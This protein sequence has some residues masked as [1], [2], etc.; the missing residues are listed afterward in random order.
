MPVGF[1]IA[2]AWVDIRAEDKGLRQEI[3]TAVENATKGQKAK[4]E[5]DILTKG[6]RKQV[7]A[8]LAEAT[9]GQS[10]KVAIGIKS[11]GLRKEVTEA[12]KR[13]TAKQKPTVKL[14]I[15]TAGL[16]S[17]VQRA[18]A[19]A[20][21]D[22]KPTVR[23]GISSKGL[24]AEV[25]TAIAAATA[26]QKATVPLKIDD[27]TF[28]NSLQRAVAGATRGARGKVKVDADG[29][30]FLNSI[31]KAV[32]DNKTKLSVDVD[33]AAFRR[34][35][36]NATSDEEVQVRARAFLN[37]QSFRRD[38]NRLA[39][40]Q[41]VQING[42]IN[43]NSLQRSLAQRTAARNGLN[44]TVN[45][46]VNV[47][48]L[49]AQLTAAGRTA[50][51]TTPSVGIRTHLNTNGFQRGAH[52]MSRLTK[53]I[54]AS[55]IFV[56]PALAV[57]DTALRAIGP[58]S[59][60]AVSGLVA[61]TT[62]G[63]TL[64]VGMNNVVNAI[65][66]SSISLDKYYGFLDQLTPAARSFVETVVNSKGAWKEFQ[67]VIQET[68]F[69]NLDKE[70]SHLATQTIPTFTVGLGGMAMVLNSMAKESFKTTVAMAKM[71]DLD[72]MFG[73]LHLAMKP[74][75]P[76]PGQILNGI[77][78]LGTAAMP[79]F[80][81]MN[82][83]MGNWFNTMTAK[84]NSAFAD[85]RL[86]AA[87]TKSADDIV[88]WFRRIAN[89]PEFE[90]FMAHMEATG[91]EMS[92][93]LGHITEALAKLLN[94]LSPVAGAIIKVANAFAELV[95]A[96]PNDFIKILL[97]AYATFK[98]IGLASAGIGRTAAAMTRLSQAMTGVAA[99]QSVMA[100]IGARL[101]TFGTAAAGILRS[102]NALG[103]LARAGLLLGGIALTAWA[104]HKAMAAAFGD[105]AVNVDK[106]TTSLVEFNK[107]GRLSGEA[108]RVFGANWVQQVDGADKKMGGLRDAIKGIAHPGTWDRM[109]NGFQKATNWLDPGKTKLEKYQEKIGGVDKAL[110]KL[111]KDG[112]MD[113]AN[114]LFGKL[115]VEARKSGT[116]TEKF[117]TL[118]PKYTEA[119]KAAKKAQKEAAETMG[120]FGQQAMDVADRIKT[121]NAEAQG[122]VKSLFE[123]NNVN[124][125]SI[126]ASKNW[127]ESADAID[128]F[129]KANKKKAVG[130]HYVNGELTTNNELQREAATLLDTHAQNT[131]KSALAVFT[132]TGS[133]DKANAKMT[134]G[135]K[136]IIDA[137][138][139]FGMSKTEAENYANAIIKIP[140]QKELHLMIAGQAEEQLLKVSAAFRAQP[141]KKTITVNTLN[142]SAIKALED[143]GYKVREL[144]D[145]KFQIT[146][147]KKPAEDDLEA[148]EGYKINPKTVEILARI[149]S[150]TLE[151][152]ELQTRVDELKQKKPSELKADGGKL[153][154]ELDAK[155]KKIDDLKQKRAVDLKALDKTGPGVKSAQK[156]LDKVKDKTVVITSVFSDLASGPAASAADAIA[157]QAENIRKGTYKKKWTGGKVSKFA[158][159]GY[160]KGGVPGFV[161]GP[162]GP[163]SDRI[164]AM[165]SNGE[166]VV[167]ASAVNKYGIGMM[168]AINQGR[169][170]RFAAG[171]P[172]SG[173]GGAAGGTGVKA[174]ETTG[175][176]TVKDGTGKPV[177]SAVQNFKAL[178]TALGQ[179][180]SEMGQKTTQFNTQFEARTGTTYKAMTAAGTQ[181]G[182]QQISRT[183]T[184]R[185]QT[186]NA[187]NQWRSGMT[188]RTNT[189][190]KTLGSQASAF[191][192]TATTRTTQTK[193]TTQGVWNSWGKGMESRTNQTYGRINSATTSF[194]KQSVSKMGGARDGM[195]A[196]WG[197]LSPKFKPPVSYLIHTVI[198]KGV[199]GSMNAIMS[200]LGGGKKVSGIG[201][202]GFATGGPV[203]GA[204]SKTSDSIP[205][206][207]SNGEFVMQARAVDKF[208]VGFFNQLNKGTMPKDGAGF[209]RGFSMG[210][211]VNIS[212]PGFATG[213]VV[214]VPSADALNKILGDGDNVG[215]KKMTD[216]IMDNYVLPLIDSGSGG[217]AMK[218]VQRAGMAHIRSNI[219]A[220]VKDNFGGAGSAAAGLR[221]AKTQHG[222]PYQW[223]GNGNPSWDCSGF[224]S[225]IESVIRG[226]KPHRRWS[227]H[228][229]NGGTPPGWKAGAARPFRVGIT[230]AGVGHTAGT[231]GKTNV[232]SAGGSAGVRVGSSAR[233]YNDG[234]FT[235]WYGY[236]GPN[237]TKA[238]TG[239]LIRGRGTAT[240]DSIPAWLSNGEY[241]IRAA[242]ARRLGT[243]Y[244]NAL[245]SGRIA[246]F[247]AG[248]KVT[249]SSSGTQYKIAY[250]D[251]LSEI[252]AKFGT[253]VSALMALNTTIKNANK[254]YAGQTIWLKKI[255][256]GGGGGSTP[257]SGGF[258]LPGM[259]KIGKSGIQSSDGINALKGFVTISQAS[260]EANKAGANIRS[261]IIGALKAQDTWGTL[262]SNFYELQNMI[263]AA[264]K[265]SAETSMLSRM[266]TVVKALTPL[267]KNLDGVN[268]KLESA[269]DALEDVKGK[270]DSL[271]ES[272]SDSIMEFGSI[273]KIGKWGTNPQTLL[274]Q[275]QTDVGKATQFG[276]MLNQLKA[277][278]I[279]ADVIGQIAEAGITGGGMST[280]ASLL[281]MT[282][283]QIEQ[284]NALQAQLT[285]QA[286]RAGESA[287]QGMY[288]AGVSA[289]QG[290]VNG[291]QSQQDAIEAQMLKIAEAMEKV[292]KQALGI[293]SP[294]RVMMKMA[295]Y[296]ADGWVNQLVARKADAERAMA[297]LVAPTTGT[298]PVATPGTINTGSRGSMVHIENINVCVSG[299][300][301]LNNPAERR[302]LAKALA[303]D[304]KEEIRRDDKKHR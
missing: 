2:S 239:G 244:L 229:F 44:T 59:A 253:T 203:Y 100:L 68:L 268:K 290:L 287:A 160:A 39:Q 154:K 76:V 75:I 211:P 231:I 147:D 69:N 291:L 277:K 26:G 202:A 121:L 18:L 105:K 212:M 249:T 37:A 237:A 303:K 142:T 98:L 299:T 148:I 245:N 83:A 64:A 161:S 246:R 236:V 189:T 150:A 95:I 58:S 296:T 199:V 25:R 119:L 33:E 104:V 180:Y 283:A 57:V 248:G 166:Y 220:F 267:Q 183:Q 73:G 201:V 276:D 54:L 186:L 55:I 173:G 190:Y 62:V 89:N 221:W 14:G 23:L 197:G 292:I 156:T 41:T 13:A 91:P 38:L 164:A 27:R 258:S 270:F 36:I 280:A 28:A 198:N 141:D 94:N 252:A 193:N 139:A 34:S 29:D 131:E 151:I 286:N 107:T 48:R 11:T 169:W 145:G 282:P 214:G 279:N 126:N 215:V 4:I 93:A 241:V 228:A 269:Q 218:D 51:R 72:R 210:G 10:P 127:E 90:Q 16:R 113:T 170:P 200:K 42:Q 8:A 124:R 7:Q 261:E 204:G 140:T 278:G 143:L 135:R 1:R 149:T 102:A 171:G 271:K 243:G 250:G 79:V 88:N 232:E 284:L 6:L 70:M 251:T 227:T 179:T 301:E 22:Q 297:T 92:E 110:A 191:Q 262:Q 222:K 17:E 153:Q 144:P 235:S 82:T 260:I 242:A 293:K 298:V 132:A 24:T 130:L 302:N 97:T 208:G 109:F 53:I 50:A 178:K 207:L 181:F 118:L 281:Q 40:N 167:R 216:F 175:T 31:Q 272:V 30:H 115:A 116:S 285:A 217:S 255:V 223:G 32:K 155:Q 86:Q 157:K 103:M 78:K 254:I 257:P 274:N 99:Q 21:K 96:L 224:M 259:S 146:A 65:T 114:A 111:V 163:T 81:R 162:G 187:W 67:A 174:G 182:R 12:L 9:K 195:G 152:D 275:L 184:T 35:L 19:A 101:R 85:G 289:A 43:V 80:I 240:S 87:I 234:M 264:F 192:R 52:N 219:E 46:N 304:I 266:S 134:E 206:R 294:S 209:P 77:V 15:S 300:F 177:A 108:A 226:E 158:H 165:L 288:G 172:V 129:I 295:D 20:T 256:S 265:G 213:G 123:M 71:G 133:W 49:R 238:A 5:L 137:A 205:A 168:N 185:T 63:A 45:T 61:L 136:K 47:N 3:K 106:L 176:F 122:L 196:A 233:G 120:V 112:H 273:T 128:K 159:G 263:K 230:H 84:L 66:A 194:S 74:L 125:D 188:N 138:I 247:G 117:Q 60:V 225:A 56:P